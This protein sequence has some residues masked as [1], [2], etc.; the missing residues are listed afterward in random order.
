M[1]V[2][3]IIPGPPGTGKTWTLVNKH[4]AN[5][6]NGL[7]T[8]PK[9]IAYVTFSNAAAS[10]ANERIKH[11]L[12]YISTLHHLGTRE[13]NINTTTQL[14]KDRKWKQFTSQSQICTGMKF[15]TKRDI[16]GNT[17]HQNPHMKIISYARSK[18]IDLIEAALQLDL[19][20][21]VDLWLTEQIDEDLN[22]I[23]NKLE[24]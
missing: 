18:K 2:R 4:L 24:W 19:H 10:E 6:I 17:V 3:T 5:E 12:L 16:Y 1:A 14:L 7:H 22:H 11:P 20:H 13:C 15:E 8:D 21:S 23:K 9:K